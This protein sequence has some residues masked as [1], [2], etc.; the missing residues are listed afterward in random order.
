MSEKD[1][2]ADGAALQFERAEL[3]DAPRGGVTCGICQGKVSDAYFQVN[4]AELC[5]RVNPI[6]SAS[7]G[8]RAKLVADLNH[9]HLI[10]DESGRVL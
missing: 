1:A 2:A 4:G 7:A 9:M 5:A 8:G 6:T 10:D 3:G